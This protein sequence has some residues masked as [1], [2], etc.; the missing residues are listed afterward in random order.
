MPMT[1]AEKRLNALQTVQG[2]KLKKI[3]PKAAEYTGY[4]LYRL[5]RDIERRAH[6][7]AEDQCTRTLREGYVEHTEATILE[8]LDH[9]LGYKAARVPIF[10]NGD[11]RGYAIKI[12]D[13]HVRGHK[14]DIHTDWGGYGILAPDFEEDG[15]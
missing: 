3:F 4:A 1:K 15:S 9:V 8:A 10:L 2:E 12:S 11:P 6:K 7:L 5:V 14:L 13:M